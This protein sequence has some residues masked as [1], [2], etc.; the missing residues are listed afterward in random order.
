MAA[1]FARAAGAAG[2]LKIHFEG[3]LDP[4]KKI[5]AMVGIADAIVSVL[6]F[7]EK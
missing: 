4:L 5:A 6:P 3:L 2:E 7:M 1:S